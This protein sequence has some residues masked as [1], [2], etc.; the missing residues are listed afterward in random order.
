MNIIKLSN[1]EYEV[2]GK[3]ILHNIN[4][5]IKQNESCCVI[6]RNGCGKSTLIELILG[7]IAKTSGSVEL[8]VRNDEISVVYNDINLFPFLKVREVIK[9]L[10]TIH[11][12]NFE[13]IKEHYFSVFDLH[14]IANSLLK[15]LSSGE[16]KKVQLLISIINNPSL[17]VLDEPFAFI[18]PTVVDSLW[19]LIKLN[20]NTILFC[21]H[22]WSFVEQYSDRIC[23]MDNGAI[24]NQPLT[25]EEIVSKLPEKKKIV[26]SKNQE[27]IQFEKYPHFYEENSMII[28]YNE[29]SNMLSEV[30]SFSSNYSVLDVTL[31]DAYIYFTTKKIVL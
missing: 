5:D 22:N 6:G 14:K 31:K 13:K 29:N 12:K 27:S 9:F 20:S 10:C 1:V 4:L 7:D 30:K 11:N 16:K 15:E 2:K 8:G 26:I 24:L 25:F 21:S 17:I 3:H 28:F 23:F 18:D 19:E